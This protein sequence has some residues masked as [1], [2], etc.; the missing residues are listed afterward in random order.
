MCYLC[1]KCIYIFRCFRRT[2]K[3]H[4][5]M[6]RLWLVESWLVSFSVRSYGPCFVCV[7]AHCVLNST[8]EWYI[9][10]FHLSFSFIFIRLF[11]FI[12]LLIRIETGPDIWFHLVW[13]ER[14]DTPCLTL[15]YTV[16]KSIFIHIWH[17]R[18][19]GSKYYRNQ[20]CTKFHDHVCWWKPLHKHCELRMARV[21]CAHRSAGM[22]KPKTT[23]AMFSIRIYT[24]FQLSQLV[25]MCG[26]RFVRFIY[27]IFFFFFHFPLSLSLTWMPKWICIYDYDSQF[28]MCQI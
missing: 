9:F 21:V 19:F 13:M 8:I 5:E 14:S 4:V 3:L 16:P 17:C 28:E 26:T 25:G 1:A 11:Y 6:S 22:W 18:A 27:D 20:N 12:F 24:V 23:N 7:C 2:F 10:F 15:S